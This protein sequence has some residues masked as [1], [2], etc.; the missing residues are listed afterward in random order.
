MPLTQLLKKENFHWNGEAE[1]A[2][3]ELKTIMSNTPVLA[4]PHFSKLI[5]TET[6]A[7]K[8]GVGAV[9]MQDGKPITYLS[10]ALCPK[11]LGLSTYEKELLTVIIATQK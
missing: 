9:M 4:L 5:V 6:N 2:F 10:K 1:A 8:L 11:H 3:N 7:S